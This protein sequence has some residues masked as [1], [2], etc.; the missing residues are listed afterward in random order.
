MKVIKT[1][2]YIK[3][4]RS[5]EYKFNWNLPDWLS[6]NEDEILVS[7][8][9]DADGGDVLIEDIRYKLIN[10]DQET[11]VEEGS[12]L[13]KD[14]ER[15]CID[16]FIEYDVGRMEDRYESEKEDYYEGLRKDRKMGLASNNINIKTA[17]QDEYSCY[18][19]INKTVQEI[20][21]DFPREL[22]KMQK[23]T[24]KIGELE[25]EIINL[26]KQGTVETGQDYYGSD[27]ITQVLAGNKSFQLLRN[28]ELWEVGVWNMNEV[29]QEYEK[30]L[31]RALRDLKWDMRD[32]NDPNTPQ[33]KWLFRG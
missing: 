16:N 11:V 18:L 8:Y 24:Q 25:A 32:Q 19:I 30:A 12:Q 22:E 31:A 1:A 33:D 20:A 3:T 10:S 17:S 27:Y 26:S 28:D 14:M 5:Q 23:H 7:Y 15:A 13:W 9:A 21:T 2:K 6:P 29:L 4:A